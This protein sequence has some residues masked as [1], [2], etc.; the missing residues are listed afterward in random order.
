MLAFEVFLLLPLASATLSQ[1]SQL[2]GSLPSACRQ[3][4]VSLPSTIAASWPAQQQLSLPS[5]RTAAAAAA[6]AAAVAA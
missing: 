3:L 1:P 4:A 2:S 5:S 6:A